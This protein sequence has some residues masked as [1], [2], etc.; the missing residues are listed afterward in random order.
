MNL[1]DIYLRK[2][3]AGDDRYKLAVLA[4]VDHPDGTVYCTTLVGPLSYQGQTWRGLGTLGR[5]SGIGGSKKLSVRPIIFELRGVPP[6][7]VT[8]ISS[9]VRGRVASAWL[10]SIDSRQRAV[11]G[12]PQYLVNGRCDDQVVKIGADRKAVVQITVN[13]PV[14][15]LDRGQT[16]MWTSQ[17]LKKTYGDTITGL[18]NVPGANVQKSWTRT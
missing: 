6:D 9:Q 15:V 5:L 13:E 2:A 7:E 18:D 11:A 1:P 3:L 4:S 10:A 16:L 14:Y 8:F 17:W 12:S